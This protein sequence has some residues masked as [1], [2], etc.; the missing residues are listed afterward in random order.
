MAKTTHLIQ[1]YD[2][3]NRTVLCVCEWFGLEGEFRKHQLHT[4]ATDK[5]PPEDPFK[6]MDFTGMTIVW[7]EGQ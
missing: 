3:R 6:G 4:P 7:S 1:E 5:K 2:A